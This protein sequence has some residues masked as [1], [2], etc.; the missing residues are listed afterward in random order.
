L[1]TEELDEVR[2]EYRRRPADNPVDYALLLLRMPRLFVEAK[3]LGSNLNDPKWAQ[4]VIGYAVV[5]G[6]EWVVLTDGNEWRIYNAHAAV[7]VEEKLFR[8]VRLDD[9]VSAPEETL[10]ALSKAQMQENLIAELWKAHSVDRLVGAAVKGL[11]GSAPDPALVR[12]V[13]RRAPALAPADIRASL[14]RVRVQLDFPVEPA[15][16]RVD[17]AARLTV[18]RSALRSA[19]RAPLARGTPWRRITLKDL[20]EGGHVRPPIDLEV[21]YKRHSL[22]ARIEADATVTWDGARYDSLSTAAGMA[23]RSIIGA[24]PGR[25]YPQ[26]N[27]WTFWR[28][29]DEAGALRAVDGLRRRAYE[30]GRE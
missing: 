15:A 20:I 2:R 13:R 11:F 30:A 29:R 7:P 26:T 24:P 6:V 12:F 25:R 27:G 9:A 19:P 28:V 16:P 8:S 21:V 18:A 1:D 3:T 23:R 4:Q 22:T 14:A 5:A 10:R 17:G